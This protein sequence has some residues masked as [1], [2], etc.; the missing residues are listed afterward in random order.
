[1][2]SL[3]SVDR[4][5]HLHRAPLRLTAVIFSWLIRVSRRSWSRHHRPAP[6]RRQRHSTLGALRLGRWARPLLRPVVLLLRGIVDDTAC[7]KAGRSKARG[8]HP[9]PAL[10]SVAPDPGQIGRHAVHRAKVP[11]SSPG[12]SPRGPGPAAIRLARST[13]RLYNG[14]KTFSGPAQGGKRIRWR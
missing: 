2:T 10:I 14:R 6:A 11:A 1:M 5:A 12:Q 7:R 3:G 8:M 4:L 13:C 9:A